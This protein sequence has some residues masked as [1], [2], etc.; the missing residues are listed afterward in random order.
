M[1][2]VCEKFAMDSNIKFSVDDNPQKSKSKC[3]V[4]TGMTKPAV[5]PKPLILC[6]KPL[7]WVDRADH[8]GHTLCSDMTTAKDTEEKLAQYID[9]SAKICEN[10]KFAHPL[11][12]ICA[13]ERYSCSMFGSSLWNLRGKE[14]RSVF[15]ARK[16][17]VK[18]AWGVPRGCRTYLLQQVLAPGVISLRV[19]LLTRF[20][21]FFQNLVD[22]VSYE[23]SVVSR[24]AAR[25]I[26]TN[27]GSNV[28]LIREDTQLDL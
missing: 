2:L 19:K 9:S 12:Q 13:I 27:L 22:N 21:G 4:I 24:L 11:D 6:G 15:S 3:M 16:K 10:F 18:L 20:L 17:S 8:L 26:R 5:K 14:C 7:P 1:I 25:D 28:S 23:V